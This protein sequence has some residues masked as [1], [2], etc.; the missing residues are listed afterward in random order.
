ML[1]SLAHE[2]AASGDT[3][4]GVM[5]EAAPAASFEVMLA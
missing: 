1:E 4:G 3:Q 2:E 5:V